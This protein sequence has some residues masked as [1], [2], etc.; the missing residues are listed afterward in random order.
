MEKYTERMHLGP[1]GS[2]TRLNTVWEG[3]AALKV[4][5]CLDEI[6][7]NWTSLNIFR[8]SI[9]EGDGYYPPPAPVTLLIGLRPQSLVDRDE[10]TKTA[11]FRCLDIFKEFDITDINVIIREVVS[12]GSH[13]T[14]Y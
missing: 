3:D 11:A 5:A 7:I 14:R 10:D 4:Q 9:G 6:G 12:W 1:A 8:I 13:A 2:H